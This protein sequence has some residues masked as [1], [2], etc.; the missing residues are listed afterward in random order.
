MVAVAFLCGSFTVFLRKKKCRHHVEKGGT[1][2][3]EAQF[4]AQFVKIMMAQKRPSQVIDA[5]YA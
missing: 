3:L 2:M 5:S 1:G 4:L